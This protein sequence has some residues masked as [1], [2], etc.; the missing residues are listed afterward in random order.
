ME[1]IAEEVVGQIIEVLWNRE[2]VGESIEVLREV[3]VESIVEYQEIVGG[4]V[5]VFGEEYHNSRYFDVACSSEGI[6]R[7]RKD[8]I[9]GLYR[10]EA[11]PALAA[12]AA[13]VLS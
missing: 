11:K 10:Y 1:S 5:V 12:A 9:E 2:I 8:K 7:W 13:F 4:S 3:E 6:L